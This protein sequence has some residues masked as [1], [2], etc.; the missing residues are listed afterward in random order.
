LQ[1]NPQDADPALLMQCLATSTLGGRDD[2]KIII[3]KPLSIRAGPLSTAE[4][5]TSVD[6]GEAED[7]VGAVIAKEV[8]PHPHPQKS[9]ATGLISLVDYCDHGKW[10]DR[11][12]GFLLS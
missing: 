9:S 11:Q 5:L 7:Q 4:R 3:C 2:R 1:R 8:R 12:R 6:S 10:H